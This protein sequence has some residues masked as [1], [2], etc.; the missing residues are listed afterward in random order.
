MEFL[1]WFSNRPVHFIAFVFGVC[2]CTAC[3]SSC[4]YFT[5]ARNNEYN[6]ESA[7]LRIEQ[8]KALYGCGFESFRN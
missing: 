8:T 3:F 1:N 7:K 2:F 6:L 5:G 4:V